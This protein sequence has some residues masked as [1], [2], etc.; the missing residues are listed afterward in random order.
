MQHSTYKHLEDRIKLSGLT[1]GQW[2]LLF[3]GSVCSYGLAQLLPLP[4]AWSL[5]IAVTIVGIP[6]SLAL[7]A[8]LSDF[9]V[10][11]LLAAVWR[12]RRS[13]RNYLPGVEPDSPQSGYVVTPAPAESAAFRPT[14][15]SMQ[16]TARLWDSP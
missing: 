1:L 2:A 15:R 14:S 5:S 9:S 3:L 8:S 12:Y 13:A 10:P 6:V 4:G 7:V 11:A 16:R